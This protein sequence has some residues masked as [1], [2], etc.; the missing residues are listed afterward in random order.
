MI[1][2]LIFSAPC[3]LFFSRF[4]ETRQLIV[5]CESW[6]NVISHGVYERGGGI[7]DNTTKLHQYKNDFR[8][9]HV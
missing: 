9:F 2:H 6:F 8:Q 5:V 7:K 4:R 3:F 1:T